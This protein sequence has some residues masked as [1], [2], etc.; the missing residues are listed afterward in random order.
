MSGP[1]IPDRVGRRERHTGTAS[2]EELCLRPHAGTAFPRQG[3]PCRS[4][5]TP[6]RHSMQIRTLLT[7]RRGSLLALLAA[8]LVLVPLPG[9]LSTTAPA[10][11]DASCPWMDP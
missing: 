1:G 8:A 9:A 11:A 5:F 3:R 2:G 10:R 4:S 7:V 6:R